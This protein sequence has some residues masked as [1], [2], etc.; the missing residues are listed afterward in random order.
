MILFYSLACKH[1]QMLLDSVKRLDAEQKI[2]L[3]NVHSLM[4]THP[5][6]YSSIKAVPA[7]MML[8][9]KEVLY[10]KLAFDY[11]LLPSRGF[12]TSV[13]AKGT[14]TPGGT[15]MGGGGGGPGGAG[16]VP[17]VL[18]VEEG[19]MAFNTSKHISSDQFAY[20]SEDSATPLTPDNNPHSAFNWASIDN[21]MSQQEM[22]APQPSAP[23]LS[24]NI[25]NTVAGVGIETRGQKEEIDIDK[26]RM[27]RDKDMQS[28]FSQ[29]TMTI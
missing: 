15:G 29:T 17:A 11:L 8:P 7:L 1:C 10:G 12:L 28:I 24:Q 16:G 26:Y 22:A 2:K 23:N 3:V 13:S 14:D 20:L 21:V 9:S 27:Q 18:H 4:T 25:P 19:V 6:I 5:S